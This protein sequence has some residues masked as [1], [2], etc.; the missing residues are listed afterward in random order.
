MNCYFTCQKLTTFSKT[1]FTTTKE[2]ALAPFNLAHSVYCIDLLG[3]KINLSRISPAK[4]SRSGPN[5]VYV[6][7]SRGDNV[8]G[9]LGAISPFWAKWGLIR[10]LRSPSF[11][12]VVSE[13]TFRQFAMPHHSGFCTPIISVQKPE[14][15]GYPMVLSYSTSNPGLNVRLTVRNHAI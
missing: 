13:T 2:T 9:I 7:R 6:E 12:C 14:W 3:R 5:L 11:F 1:C 8:G 4:R 15:C 10:V